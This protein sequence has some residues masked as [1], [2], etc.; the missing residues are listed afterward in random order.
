MPLLVVI[1]LGGVVGS[2][3]RF[4][5]AETMGPWD[6]GQWPWATLAVNVV[7]A[8]AIGMVAASAM[9]A[10]GPHWLRP[11]V[12]TGVLGGFT[13]F[14][15]LALETGLLLQAGR[16]WV[17]AAYLGG[18][19]ILGLLAVQLGARVVRGARGW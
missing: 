4:A 1:A 5:V 18:T 8:L 3:G 2:L 9:V 13:T 15:A 6:S 17:A 16:L 12:I 19:L 14:S 10:R 11:F 7:G